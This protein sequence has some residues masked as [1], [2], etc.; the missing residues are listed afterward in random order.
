MTRIEPAK[1]RPG[2]HAIQKEGIAST[3]SPRLCWVNLKKPK[4]ARM[5]SLMTMQ[6]LTEHNEQKGP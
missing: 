1:Q 6:I 3:K 2:G 4:K 5:P